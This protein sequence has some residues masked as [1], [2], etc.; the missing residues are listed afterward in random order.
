MSI[1][2]DLIQPF[3][4]DAGAIR[5]RAV[6]LGPALDVIMAGHDYPPAV[7]ALL[8]ETLVLA[9]ALAGALKFD[10]IFTL[11]IQADGAI[12]L[13]VADVTSAGDLRGYARF[14]AGK[15]ATALAA[16]GAVV[17]GLIGKGYLA[18]T[19]DQ[20]PDT[21][22]YQGIVELEGKTLAECAH[23]YFEQSEQLQ[24]HLQA[25]VRAPM[26][27]DGWRGGAV[28][29]QRMPLGQNSPIFTAEEADEA[30]NRAA[31]LT[32][33]VRDDELLG[34]KVGVGALLHR[35]Y[36]AEGLHP[37]DPKPL[38]ANCRCSAER[39][40]GTLKSFP[41][42]E[43]ESMRDDSGDVVVVCEFCKS[44]Y[45]FANTDLDRLYQS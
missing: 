6:R 8:A 24:T 35:L 13:I 17:P 28:M 9:A 21:D 3:L 33:S 4:I 7:A 43:V 44:R 16:G 12:P 40:A 36:H 38:A 11:Q 27:S 25:A 31:I 30:W 5:G 1:D 32:A 15:L 42:K 22:R 20:G 45:V 37:H 2:N 39:V 41:R 14:D 29:I 10:G 34:P 18:F 23:R 26:G 19:V